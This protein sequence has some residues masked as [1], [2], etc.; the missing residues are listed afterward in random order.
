M[1]KCWMRTLSS[2]VYYASGGP[3]RFERNSKRLLASSFA[4][5]YERLVHAL[6]TGAVVIGRGRGRAI[7]RRVVLNAPVGAGLVLV[8]FRLYDRAPVRRSRWVVGARSAGRVVCIGGGDYREGLA[9]GASL[10]A[11]L[12]SGC[13]S[14]FPTS[15]SAGTTAADSGRRGLVVGTR[16]QERLR[17]D[18]SAPAPTFWPARWTS[19]VGRLTWRR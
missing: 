7:R 16:G 19:G 9:R 12:A 5:L 4:A 2:A 18:D 13:G 10:A 6:A 17:G 3:V 14:R 11:G 8:R 1:V 15:A